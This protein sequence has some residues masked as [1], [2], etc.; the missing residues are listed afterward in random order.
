MREQRENNEYEEER[1]LY[2]HKEGEPTAAFK[3]A[4]N[5]ISSKNK[6][7]HCE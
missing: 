5:T 7:T 3:G 2:V 6:P 1:K 4:P